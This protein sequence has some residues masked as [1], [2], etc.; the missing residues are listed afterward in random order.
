MLAHLV[1]VGCL[2]ELLV[3]IDTLLDENLF[4]R[5]EVQLLQ[6]LVLAYLQ[7]LTDEVLGTLGTVYQQV[8]H[9]KELRFVVLDDAAVR[10]DANL[11]VGKGIERIERLVAADARH[12]LHLNLDACRRQVVYVACFDL[13]L[14]DGFLNTVYQAVNGLRVGQVAYDERFLVQ[15]LNLRPHLQH[16]AALSVVVFAHVDAAACL[17]VGIEVELLAVQVRDGCIAYLTEVM[18]QDFR[19]QAHGNTLGSLR[20][21]QRELDG[22][23]DRLLVASVVTQLPLRGLGVKH[24]IQGKLG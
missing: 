19:R 4:Q 18:G 10:R 14:L 2:L 5:L 16:A 21:Q 17:E 6:Q 23:G 8:A 7:F 22:Q 13:A 11:A 12:E 1:Y 24:G 20:E 15:F 9:G 3:L